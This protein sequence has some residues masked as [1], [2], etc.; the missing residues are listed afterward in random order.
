[1]SEIRTLGPVGL[2][3]LG[4]YNSQTEYEKLD[5]VLY[6]GSSYV[7]LKPVQG[8]VPTN[9]E[10]WQKLV[11]GGVGVDDIV[12]NLESNDSDKPLS[13]RQGK[14]LNDDL[15]TAKLNISKN[16]TYINDT[17]NP[18]YYGADPTG[19][20][21]SSTAINECIQAN[22]GGT[23]N[24]TIGTYLVNSTINLPYKDSE[25]VSING[26]GAKIETT[27]T[28]DRLIYAGFD[29][30]SS[31]VNNVG[32][33][34][35][36][37]DL[38]IDGVN[39]NITY[40]I[41]N[42]TGFKDLKILNCRIFRF[43]NGIL[44]GES[45]GSPADMLITD[46]LIYGKG[47]EY[48]GVG[49]TTNCTDSNIN[50]CRIYGFRKGFVINGYSIISRSH[51]LLRWE[52]Q[53]S[54]NFDPYPINT[55][56]FNEYYEPTMFAELNNDCRILHC[57]CD[58][59]YM[60]AYVTT[61]KPITIDTSLYYNS[62][63]VNMHLFEITVASP[64]INI[65]GNTFSLKKND[66]CQVIVNKRS[67]GL[68]SNA[69]QLNMKNNILY[70]VANLTSHGDLILSDIK[71]FHSNINMVADTWYLV[72]I[73]SNYNTDTN[74]TGSLYIIG[75]KYDINYMYNQE[76]KQLNKGS[77][78]TNY[79]VG[80]IAKDQKLYICLKNSSVA[81]NI[82][83]DFSLE[84]LTYYGYAVTPVNGNDISNST[85]LLSDYIEETPSFTLNL[86]NTNY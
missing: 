74:F 73:I 1:M 17:T 83:F 4:E 55:T 52:N 85:R 40:A 30:G 29:R 47:S 37:K 82:K 36:I 14:K 32:Y 13:A 79:T 86:Y 12:D 15:T 81:N 51:V 43:L 38:N 54:S 16:A 59:T 21:D 66:D 50:M 3:P 39:G 60:F 2:N 8:I 68:F 41:E 24:F 28:L 77:G 34:S 42:K 69:S 6:Q 46:C 11:S 80:V 44:I 10:Y 63:N 58:S 78:T 53:T 72:K 49:I 26:N 65:I 18:I 20:L 27:A 61:E 35:Y 76:I 84:H 5:V 22:K 56:E 23:I 57:Y 45:T 9:A 64:R 7:A 71:G 70:N 33:T 67:N 19:I 75:N 25:K 31:P 62:R 48:N